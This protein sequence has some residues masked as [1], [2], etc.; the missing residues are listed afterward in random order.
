MHSPLALAILALGTNDF[1]FC[2]PF[3]DAWAAAQGMAALVKS[4]REAPIEPGMQVPQ[5]LWVAPPPIT[6]P[7]GSIAPKFRGADKRCEGVAEAY[8]ISASELGC[9]CV[10]AGA[11]TSSSRVDGV[12]LDEDQHAALGE[13]IA[14]AAEAAIGTE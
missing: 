12:H 13:F 2:H 11:V 10:D 9:L 8:R 14:Q 7:R 1:Q 6:R 3:N 5:I 4:I